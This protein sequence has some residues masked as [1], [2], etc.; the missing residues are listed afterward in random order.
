M[1]QLHSYFE[2]RP[3]AT[4]SHQNRAA[5]I[6]TFLADELQ[7]DGLGASDLLAVY[8]AMGWSPPRNPNA[9][10]TNATERNRYFG[11]MREGRVHLTPD[12]R[13]LRPPR[14]QGG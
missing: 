11:G 9:V 4:K 10:I 2:E 5:V 12:G 14:V 6:A 13:A 1:R 7:V 3:K 8:R